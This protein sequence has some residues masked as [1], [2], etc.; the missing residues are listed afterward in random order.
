L[1]GHSCQSGW[2]R[3]EKKKKLVAAARRESCPPAT[4]NTPSRLFGLLNSA[5]ITGKP[6][7]IQ[8]A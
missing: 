7:V 8:L 2:L 3:G 4:L 5:R 6:E 1:I